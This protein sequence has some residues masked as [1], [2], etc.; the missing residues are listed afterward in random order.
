M[1]SL[2]SQSMHL[3]LVN[4]TIDTDIDNIIN[5]LTDINVNSEN[6]EDLFSN[7]FDSDDGECR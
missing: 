1:S 3:N 6:N 2:N 5:K 7:S 4:E